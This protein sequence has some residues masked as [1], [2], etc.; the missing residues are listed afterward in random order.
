[1]LTRRGLLVAASAAGMYLVGWGFGIREVDVT[2]VGL[3]L[4]LGVAALY[5]RLTTRA[6]YRLERTTGVNSLVEGEP[7]RVD[8]SVAASGL[9]AVP[10][11]ATLD[12][13]LTARPGHAV[14]RL[15]RQ[16]GALVGGYRIE[17]MARGV[18]LFERAQ[19]SVS[20][21]LG[22]ARR[23]V[24]LA[25]EGRI[26]VH[27]KLVSVDRSFA[28][29]ASVPG[30]SARRMLLTRTAGFSIHGVR[31]YV[32]GESL[33]QIHWPSTARRGELMV[34]ELEDAPRDEIAIVLD[35]VS[36]LE[37][38]RAPDSSFEAQVRATASLL[39]HA[40]SSGRRVV[41][42]LSGA[43]SERLPVATLEHDFRAALDVLA[44]VRPLGRTALPALLSYDRTTIDAI[45]LILVTAALDGRLAERA[46][47]LASRR[48]V[49]VC[50]V[51]APS[52]RGQPRDDAQGAI[53]RGLVRAGVAYTRIAQGS[54]LATALS[55]G[56]PDQLGYVA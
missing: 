26:V 40:V 25:D 35:T 36:G 18:V 31:Q 4:T 3:A 28:D 52:W 44:A 7:F 29:L 12:D 39:R 37:V 21:P 9:L 33:R 19:L 49:A 45:Q 1:M 50:H 41:L 53:V 22:L 47:A 20:D 11:D 6:G 5:V 48:H 15:A 2:A 46:I 55:A 38:G 32:D 16:G 30:G 8:I 13:G 27:P 14:H 17:G 23:S 10:L 42:V 24:E 54:E 56:V 34:K 43:G 51:D